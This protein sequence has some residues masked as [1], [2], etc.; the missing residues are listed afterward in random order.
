MIVE[1]SLLSSKNVLFVLPWLPYPLSSGGHQAIFNGI[2]AVCKDVKVFVTFPSYIPVQTSN[3]EDF[4]KAIGSEIEVLPYIYPQQETPK[5]KKFLLSLYTPLWRV[6][7]SFRKLMLH[8]EEAYKEGLGDWKTIFRLPDDRFISHVLHVISEKHIDIVQCE[9]VEMLSSGQFLPSTVKKIFVH[10]ELSFVK[11]QLILNKRKEISFKDKAE[12]QYL[13]TVEHTLLESFDGIVTLS[14]IDTNK[15]LDLCLRTPIFTSFAITNPPSR[16]DLTI[17][18]NHVVSFV[19]PQ[20]HTP[21]Y[22]GLTWFI[23]NCWSP[24]M[25]LDPLLTLKII[26]KWEKDTV[27]HICSHNKRIEFVGYADDLASELYGTTMIVPI[28]VGSGIRMKILEAA[29]IGIPFVSTS[30]GAE[31]IP[32]E[33][34]KHCFIA[35]SPCEFIDAIMK[36]SNNIK[37]KAFVSN[38]RQLIIESYSLDAL[39][40]NRL[41]IYQKVYRNEKQ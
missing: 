14:S 11:H 19:G 29:S 30:V 12:L 34:G 41:G 40:E 10:H 21:N 16:T 3:V 38:A 7:V 4:R 39:R 13:K 2:K 15:L 22:D 31:G 18:Y 23:E 1:N 5:Y 6:K 36:L 33:N 9:M 24:L 37:R 20:F 32:V 27:S 25:Q 8:S 28:L 17:D 26:G 35:D